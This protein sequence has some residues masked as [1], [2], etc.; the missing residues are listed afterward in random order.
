MDVSNKIREARKA[1]GL[2][3]KGLA[4]KAGLATITIQQYESNKRQPRLDQLQKISHALGCPLSAFLQDD[5]IDIGARIRA[6]RQQKGMTQKQVADKCGMADS[7]IRKYES[8]AQVPK[9]ETAKRIA[10]ALNVPPA[11]LLGLDDQI[12]PP[13]AMLEATP[14]G[15][16][17]IT[18]VDTN[19]L[20]EEAFPP[21]KAFKDNPVNGKEAV[22][23]NKYRSLNESG[24]QKATD[25]I[26]DLLKVEQYRLNNKEEF[27]QPLAPDPTIDYDAAIEEAEAEIARTPYARIAAYGGKN[28]FVKESND[29]QRD[30]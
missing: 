29:E 19:T 3:Q 6:I 2:T 7:A 26:D 1:A 5:N 22:L 25:Y 10:A 21:D 30:K 15:G 23:I 24:Q 27:A 11:Q 13:A 28:M 4:E 14:G 17:R 12:I 20:P 16:F 8:G 18:P 9:V